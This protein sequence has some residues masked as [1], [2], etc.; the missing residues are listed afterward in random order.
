MKKISFLALGILSLSA[1]SST[2]AAT[3]D[4]FEYGFNI[5][6]A[7]SDIGSD[8]IPGGV[9]AGGFNATTG[10]GSI[11]FSISG[12]GTHYFSTYYDHELDQ[13][14]NTFF[15]E[16]GFT[17]GA[18]TAGQSWE[19]DEPGFSTNPGDIFSNFTNG[20]LD[21]SIGRATPDD[22]AM[23]LGW[24]FNLGAFD[25]AKITLLT[26]ETAPTSGFYLEQNDPD[27]QASVFL[28]GSLS[29]IS[30]NPNGV[31]DS[32]SSAG[33]LALGLVGLVVSSQRLSRMSVAKI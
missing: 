25:T 27:S 22:V 14:V 6:G 2:R 1:F 20:T 29:I 33:L 24:T 12:A 18:P 21:N 10:L 3:V 7:V 4:L 32:G 5:D 15:N 26:S 8:P 19:I 28:S 11:Q 17:F 13:T 9:N 31:P 30:R 23:A 16:L